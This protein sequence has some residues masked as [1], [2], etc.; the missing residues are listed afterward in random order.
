MRGGVSE[1]KPL[2]SP[3]FTKGGYKFV[4][5]QFIGHY[6]INPDNYIYLSV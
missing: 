2:K 5:A 3:L 6:P 4:V 1:V